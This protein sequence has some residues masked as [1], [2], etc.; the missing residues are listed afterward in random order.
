LREPV[1]YITAMLR[2]LGASVA[3]FN[4]LPGR[5]TLMGQNLFYPP[6]V[7]NYFSLNYQ[8]PGLNEVAGPEFEILTPANAL[9]RANFADAV[10]FSRLGPAVTLDLVPYINLTS[11]HKW[12]LSEALNRVLFHGRMPEAVRDRILI[13]L[14]SIADPGLQAQT[15]AYLA[16]SSLLYQVQN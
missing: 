4:P 3:E 5:V 6:T 7:F 13:A 9:A 11:V 8:V 14:D 15:A 2:A 10:A 1:L 16:A 12:Y